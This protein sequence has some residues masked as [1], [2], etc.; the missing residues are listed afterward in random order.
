MRRP[1]IAFLALLFT[2]CASILGLHDGELI[3]RF[4]HRAHL[5]N[6]V[7]CL[8]CHNGVETLEAEPKLHR[9]GLDN[10]A[11]CHPKP[12]V[13]RNCFDCHVEQGRDAKALET[14]RYLRF[15]HKRHLDDLHGNCARCHYEVTEDRAVTP[16]MATCLSCH[17]HQDA[18]DGRTCNQCHL[19]LPG[20]ASRP[21]SHAAH[22][23]DFTQ[24][25]GAVAGSQRD[26]CQTCHG[27]RFCLGCHGVSVPFLPAKGRFDE[28]ELGKNMLHRAGFRA[29][30]ALEA[31]AAPG[32]CTVCH[33]PQSCNECHR[34][35][36]IT[37]TGKI[38]LGPHP[39]GWV[40]VTQADNAHGRAARLDP[41][42][43]AACHS[44]AGEA[45]CAECHKVGGIGGNVHPLG[46][47]SNKPF[48]E[49]PCRLC[50]L[51]GVR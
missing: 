15:E 40:G 4:P 3:R 42:S 7:G 19:D 43:C 35:A 20:E 37:P 9:P 34:G 23:P 49:A 30:H 2:A 16:A 29:R 38:S 10:C 32:T 47:K 50:H 17:Q 6:G 51:G 28:V 14:Q 48:S 5:A 33:N 31:R 8:D 12:H 24:R 46:W 21:A 25:H 45:L 11:R 44:G 1:L 26:Y 18:Y 27:D 22:G 13:D 39:P 41:L 36:G